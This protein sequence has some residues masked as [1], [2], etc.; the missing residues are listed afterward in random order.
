MCVKHFDGFQWLKGA[1]FG[2][3]FLSGYIHSLF[4]FP[5]DTTNFDLIIPDFNC[6]LKSQNSCFVT[7]NPDNGKTT[8]FFSSELRGCAWHHRHAQSVIHGLAGQ[9]IL[10]LFFRE[11][12]WQCAHCCGLCWEPAASHAAG[13]WGCRGGGGVPRRAE[14]LPRQGGWVS[15]GYHIVNTPNSN[16]T[17]VV[18]SKAF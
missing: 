7:L 2:C 4:G 13:T 11:P 3:V 9:F 8:P 14:K 10:P 15:L 17:S 6:W 5:L 12:S 1:G 16:C 18:K